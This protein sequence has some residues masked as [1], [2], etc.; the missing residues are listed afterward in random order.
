MLIGASTGGPG[1]IEKIITAL[2]DNINGSIIIAQ[3]MQKAL[4]KSFANRLDRLHNT[5][6]FLVQESVYIETNHLYILEDTSKV[7][8]KNGI[9]FLKK[10]LNYKDLYHPSIDTLFLSFAKIKNTDISAYLLSGIGDDGAK[11]L[12]ELKKCGYK[13]TAQD[14]KTS[15]V[16]GMPK[17]AKEIN[18]CDYVKS[19]DEIINDIKREVHA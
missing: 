16:Y 11:G 6:A 19:I 10:E 1:L 12:L 7:F 18:G 17:V 2:P 8:E 5:T 3:H 15:I 9:L 4:L 13:T 14:E